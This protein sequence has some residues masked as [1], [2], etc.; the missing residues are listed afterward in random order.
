MNALA[1]GETSS[2][3]PQLE[4]GVKGFGNAA[5]MGPCSGGGEP[6]APPHSYLNASIGLICDAFIAG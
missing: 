5:G 3:K 6:P 4:A 1:D 2:I